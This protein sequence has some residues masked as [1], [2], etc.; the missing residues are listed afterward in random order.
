MGTS[1]TRGRATI[2]SSCRGARTLERNHE[3]VEHSRFFN[4][5][6]AGQIEHT[7]AFLDKIEELEQQWTQKEL[8]GASLIEQW[9][10]FG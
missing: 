7:D 4:R 10:Q 5:R 1:P 9:E 3:I 6:L 2:P 8:Q